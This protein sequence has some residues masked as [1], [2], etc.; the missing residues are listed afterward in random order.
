MKA[1]LQLLLGLC[2]AASAFA[3][4]EA[5]PATAPVPVT[6]PDEGLRFNFR[7]APLEQVLDYLSDAAGLVIVLD[8][9]GPVR[10]TVDMWST[11]PVSKTEA[12]SLL[13]H[14]LNKNGYTAT[15]QGRSLVIST[16]DY[17]R[18]Q[19]LPVRTG[20]DPAAI[21]PTADMVT[22][23]IPLRQIG[24]AQA[25]KDIATLIP[26][27][28]AITA[29]DDS[30]SLIVTDTQINVRHIVEL[31]SQLDGSTASDTELK[32][33]HLH[34]ADATEMAGLITNLYGSNTSGS[35]SQSSGA[36]A[37]RAAIFSRFA[38]RAGGGGRRGGPGAGGFSPA[39]GADSSSHAPVP[40]TAIAD[41][42]TNSVVVTAARDTLGQIDDIIHALDNSDAQKQHVHVYSL[43]NADVQQV[44]AVLKELFPS[45]TTN[46]NSS[47]TQPDALTARAASNTQ[48]TSGSFLNNTNGPQ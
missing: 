34:N 14:A 23:I 46:N 24:A 33:F 37:F 27:S 28:T 21:P 11:Q 17:A 20:N 35:N 38:G 43:E 31:V 5:P 22:Q 32:I 25:A 42:R 16:K 39:A 12:V 45:T 15:L 4:G 41:P 7:G 47:T 40:T 18:R 26:E 30:N 44:E 13:N 8:T 9:P 1:L 29:N 19:D 36:A 10:G 2:L 48:Q 3:A 6:R